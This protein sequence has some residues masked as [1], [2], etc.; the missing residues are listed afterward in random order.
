M[1]LPRS[2]LVDG[3]VEHGSGR[4]RRHHRRR[5]SRCTIITALTQVAIILLGL[6]M[7]IHM[8]TYM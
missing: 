3:D 6:F 1:I 7:M 5:N 4:P 8:V 2:R